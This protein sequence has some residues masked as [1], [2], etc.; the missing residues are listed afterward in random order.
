MLWLQTRVQIVFLW[1]ELLQ[2]TR[3]VENQK[4][5]KKAKSFAKTK[6]DGDRSA[7][8]ETAAL[9][10]QH[11]RSLF[12]EIISLLTVAAAAAAAAA[13]YQRLVPCW[14]PRRRNTADL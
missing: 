13:V 14:L 6:A 12:T 11:G 10:F 4:N 2:M 1:R 9:S 5:Q 3:C 7:F 8:H